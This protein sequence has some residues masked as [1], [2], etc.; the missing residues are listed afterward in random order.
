[1]R[2]PD[3][4]VKKGPARVKGSTSSSEFDLDI[5]SIQTDT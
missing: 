1:M 4:A 5:I 3:E 2:S